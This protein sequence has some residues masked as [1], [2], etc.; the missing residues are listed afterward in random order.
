MASLVSTRTAALILRSV[1]VRLH[2]KYSALSLQPDGKILIGGSFRFTNVMCVEAS[3]ALTLMAVLNGVNTGTNGSVH[4]LAISPTAGRDRRQFHDGKQ[5][6]RSKVALLN[7]DGSLD[8]SF[9]RECE[10][11]RHSIYLALQPD[12]KVVIAVSSPQSTASHA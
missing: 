4:A 9:R 7:L 5:R 10:R 12:G 2:I 3:L 6:A 1:R 8:S 11:G